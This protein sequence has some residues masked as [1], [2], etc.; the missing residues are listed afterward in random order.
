MHSDFRPCRSHRLRRRDRTVPASASPVSS[1]TSAASRPRQMRSIVSTWSTAGNG[2]AAPEGLWLSSSTRALAPRRSRLERYDLWAILTF[3]VAVATGMWLRHG[4]A[5]QFSTLGGALVGIGQIS[6]LY[7]S[8]A[9]LAMMLLIARVPWI[10]R[11]I[12][13]DLLNHWHRWAAI[14][15]AALIG[16][17]LVAS[18]VGYAIVE[19]ASVFAQIGEFIVGWPDMVTA[20]VG[21]ALFY[22]VGV[23]SARVARRAM[24]YELWWL[25][26]LLAYVAVVISFFHELSTGADFYRDTLATVYWVTIHVFVATCLLVFRII[27]PLVSAGRYR[28]RIVESRNGPDD[29]VTIALRGRRLE[30]MRV[31]AGQ[32][33]LLRFLE[34]GRWWKAHPYSLS[35]APDGSSLRF[36]IKALGDDSAAVSD[37]PVGT[38]VLAE[39]PYGAV[40]PAAATRDK[41]ALIGGGIGITPI[42]AMLEGLDRA[43]G[44]VVVLYRA[45]H[46]DQ[47]PLLDELEQLAAT[48]GHRLVVSFSGDP[49]NRDDD[50]F[51]P[52]R[53]FETFPDLAD[54]DVFLCGPPALLSGAL[55]GLE[56]AGVPKSQIH[57]EQ[58]IY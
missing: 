37:L 3:N 29:T 38:R 9:L 52:Q 45:R 28:L 25:I 12:G 48:R 47:A 49:D 5:E 8:I 33:F 58:F 27:V 36:T 53:L 57:Y 46:R 6:S 43:P 32:F 14:A 30:R 22:V 21:T 18:T 19:G 42:R 15:A 7:A 39:G 50:P 44:D 41:V 20:F 17:H 24:T 55:A 2:A 35:A 40:T 10:E 34:R 56:D 11:A 1:S 4:G 51:S 23:T 16:V 13:M 26:H 31:A 54:R